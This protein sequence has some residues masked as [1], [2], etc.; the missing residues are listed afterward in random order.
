MNYKFIKNNSELSSYLS[1]FEDKKSAIIALDTE[2]ELNLHAYGETL[3]LVQIFDGA[4]KVLIDPFKIDK[5]LLKSFFEN[6]NILKIIYDAASDLSLMKNAYGTEIKSILDLRPAVTLL[7]LEKQDLHSVLAAELGVLLTNKAKFQKHN[8]TL[9]PIS[10]AALEYALSD[11][12]YLF[13]LKDVLLK[14]LCDNQLMDS[15]ILSNLKIQNK[16]YTLNPEDKYTRINGFQYLKDAEKRV[17][18]EVGKIIEKYAREYN[19]PSHWIINKNA[20]IEIIKD[21]AYLN[22][23]QFPKRLSQDSVLSLLS[24][25]K[26]AAKINNCST[27]IEEMA[28]VRRDNDVKKERTNQDDGE[29]SS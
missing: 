14:K 3:C 10:A 25:L 26:A 27:I 12:T 21:P 22:K 8:W 18:L 2:A 11:V 13:K 6:R 16:D 19:I 17:A 4:N 23:I 20:V 9:R 29:G 28:Y 24:K 7:N 1:T 5:E 15:Y